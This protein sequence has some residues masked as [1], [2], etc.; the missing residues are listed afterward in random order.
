M[1]GAESFMREELDAYRRADPDYQRRNSYTPKYS[2]EELRDYV[3]RCNYPEEYAEEETENTFE[4]GALYNDGKLKYI[5]KAKDREDCHLL[6]TKLEGVFCRFFGVFFWIV[7]SV[8]VI[9][10]LF[11][12][13]L[14]CVAVSSLIIRIRT[15]ICV[16]FFSHETF[17]AFHS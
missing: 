5:G 16:Q 2:H 4:F 9:P 8:N 11:M 7:T 10:Q 3:H 17:C 6:C 14:G 15:P 13:V 12:A 1:E